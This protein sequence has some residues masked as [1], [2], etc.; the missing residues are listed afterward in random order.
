M[1][2][3]QPSEAAM[4][5]AHELCPCGDWKQAGAGPIRDRCY[6][7]PSTMETGN[8]CKR[9]LS[10]ARGIDAARE[11]GRM[12]AFEE[13]YTEEQVV[14][15]KKAA[16]R[17]GIEE[18]RTK[19]KDQLGAYTTEVFYPACGP[20]SSNGWRGNEECGLLCGRVQRSDL[21]IRSQEHA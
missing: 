14:L 9:H 18:V 19:V 2:D 1:T 21:P 13:L 4:K 7:D 17:A 8:V 6:P 3:Q 11:E 12:R 5:Q 16:R 20:R 10:I 15:H